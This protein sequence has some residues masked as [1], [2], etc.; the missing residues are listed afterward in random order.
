MLSNQVG[1]SLKNK[2]T[3]MLSFLN[4]VFTA[5]FYL[6]KFYVFLSWSLFYLFRT[7]SISLFDIERAFDSAYRP[8]YRGVKGSTVDIR[9]PDYLILQFT[10][11][12]FCGEKTKHLSTK[13]S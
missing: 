12:N 10:S 3:G 6:Q 7:F 8:S 2:Q 13:N 9:E 4:F 11:T 1:K 5:W